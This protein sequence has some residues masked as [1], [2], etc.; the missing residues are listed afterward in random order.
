LQKIC[1][2]TAYQFLDMKA[3]NK[4]LRRTSSKHECCSEQ[5]FKGLEKNTTYL[6]AE[7]L[8]HRGVDRAMCI[9]QTFTNGTGSTNF[10]GCTTNSKPC[11]LY[12]YAPFLKEDKGKKYYSERPY[13]TLI[14]LAEN[15]GYNTTTNIT[16]VVDDKNGCSAAQQI[17][18]DILKEHPLPP[19]AVVVVA[20]EH[21]KLMHL[22]KVFGVKDDNNKKGYA[23]G[24]CSNPS[25]PR[26]SCKCK[27]PDASFNLTWTITKGE[28]TNGTQ[29]GC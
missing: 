27:Y 9:G 17:K 23:K 16:K 26:G 11:R 8:S 20:Y 7:S 18:Y 2:A 14:P 13:Q 5:S 24:C 22:T 25:D 4:R 19:D 1:N 12:A 21:S 10:G 15:L 3:D 28:F 29:I 6:P